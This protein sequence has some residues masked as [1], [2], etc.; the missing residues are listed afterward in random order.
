MIQK[1]QSLPVKSKGKIKH[2]YT[3]HT[4]LNYYLPDL[5]EFLVATHRVGGG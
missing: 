2:T 3:H 4:L 1:H 5:V